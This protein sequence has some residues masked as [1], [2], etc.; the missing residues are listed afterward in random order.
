MPGSLEA[1]YQESGRAGR[2]D[3]DARCVLLYHKQDRRTQAFFLTGKYPRFDAITGVHAALRELA[4]TS[5]VVALGDVQRAANGTA[6]SKV[7]VVL[8]A[9]KRLDLVAEPDPGE[10]RLLR[11]ELGEPEFQAIARTY[12]E[13]HAADRERLE[14]MVL[15]AQT[16]L[17]RWRVLVEY[18]GE[19][20][21]WTTCGRCDNCR[22]AAV[23][24]DRATSSPRTTRDLTPEGLHLEHARDGRARAAVRRGDTIDVPGH[25]PAEVCAIEHDKIE[26]RF[27]DGEVKKF[28]REYLTI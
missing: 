24:A 18:F 23:R 22:R 10:F 2:D 14:R 6:R 27:P 11:T 21:D 13:R 1:Y 3:R 25:G 5:R 7:R 20:V 26:L 17:C 8:D 4:A 28:R 15:Y 12:E 16:A 19:T 9:M